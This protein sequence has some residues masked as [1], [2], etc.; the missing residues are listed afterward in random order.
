M[1]KNIK[2][3]LAFTM[4]LLVNPL[5]ANKVT[6]GVFPYFNAS[7]IATLHKPLKDYLANSTDTTIRLVSASD[8]KTFKERTSKARYD[9]LITA[10]HLGRIAQKTADYEWLG[11]TGNI[12]YAVFVSH[13]DNNINSIQ[14]L[15]DKTIALPPKRAIIH[16]LA[17]ETLS[18]NNIDPTNDVKISLSKSHN[19]A[20]HSAILKNTDAAAFGAPTWNKY[21]LADKSKL[22]VLGKS[23]SIPGFAIM[24]HSKTSE[25]LKKNL[26]EA[27]FLFS[28]TKEGKIY[29]DKT[30]LKDVREVTQ[31]DM[32][33]IDKYL[34]LMKNGNTNKSKN[35]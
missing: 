15:K 9:I 33:L 21:N 10:P 23:E 14:D 13:I 16:Y 22:K 7:Y 31:L 5:Y 27:L 11:F 20:M 30:G 3:T 8:F 6:L 34:K 19:N 28:K 24:V 17:L 4:C 12:S 2:I 26:K 29:F 32:E 1:Y 18:K 35:K 25:K